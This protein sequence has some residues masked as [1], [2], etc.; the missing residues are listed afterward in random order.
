MLQAHAAYVNPIMNKRFARPFPHAQVVRQP[1]RTGYRARVEIFH[2][3]MAHR[4]HAFSRFAC[5]DLGGG[6]ETWASPSLAPSI[7][8]AANVPNARCSG[9]RAISEGRRPTSSINLERPSGPPGKG[10]PCGCPSPSADADDEVRKVHR[11]PEMSARCQLPRLSQSIKW[12]RRRTQSGHRLRAGTIIGP[13]PA[14]AATPVGVPIPTAQPPAA[15]ATADPSTAA[16]QA[17]TTPGP[18][19]PATVDDQNTDNDVW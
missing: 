8:D 10:K 16:G 12:R 18:S 7:E 14:A 11:A 4:S 5:N 19:S 1:A 9:A 3:A 15:S 17:N 13:S 2:G 6:R